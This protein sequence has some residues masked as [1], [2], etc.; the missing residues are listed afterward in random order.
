M[1]HATVGRIVLVPIEA[2]TTCQIVPDRTFNNGGDIAPAVITRVCS[3]DLVNV[4][5]LLD[6]NTTPW[7]TSL[8]LY[9]TPEDYTE[10]RDSGRPYG[11]YWPP[12]V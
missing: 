5:V 6:G 3:D 4:R 9:Q 1:H 2:L 12:R 7:K 8:A 10:A 11:C